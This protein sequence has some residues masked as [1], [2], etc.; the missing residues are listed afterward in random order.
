MTVIF[1]ETEY[2]FQLQRCYCY[3]III[4]IQ[5]I[6][7]IIISKLSRRKKPVLRI[8]SFQS[9]YSHLSHVT[10]IFTCAVLTLKRLVVLA[11]FHRKE[12]KQQVC[13]LPINFSIPYLDFLSLLYHFQDIPKT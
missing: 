3:I 9:I 8:Q 13:S 4:I 7:I 1:I 12:P 11:S 2:P 10:F 5:I 6:M